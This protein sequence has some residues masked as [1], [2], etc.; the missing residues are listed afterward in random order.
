MRYIPYDGKFLAP[1]LDGTDKQVTTDLRSALLTICYEG[2][3]TLDNTDGT[4]TDNE[5]DCECA[6]CGDSFNDGDGYWA[7]TTGDDHICNYCREEHFTY[8]Y[9]RRGNQYYIHNDD[10]V[11]VESLGEYFHDNYLAEN[12]IV[13]LAE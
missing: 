4:P 13:R 9:T 6:N 3:Y 11:Y 8:A 7:G 2:E 12:G 1:Y 10:V 5:G